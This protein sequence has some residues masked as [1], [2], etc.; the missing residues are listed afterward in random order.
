MGQLQAN[1]LRLSNLKGQRVVSSI[2]HDA[3]H[4]IYCRPCKYERERC[5]ISETKDGREIGDGKQWRQIPPSS[6]TSKQYIVTDASASAGEGI[7][8]LVQL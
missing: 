6:T 1:V 3:I 8:D 5:A 4:D 7:T 2:Y